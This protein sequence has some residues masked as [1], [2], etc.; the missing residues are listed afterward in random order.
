MKI[1]GHNGGGSRHELGASFEKPK[2]GQPTSSPL[3][4]D[5]ISDVRAV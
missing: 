4:H 1:D 5:V 3:L 2:R